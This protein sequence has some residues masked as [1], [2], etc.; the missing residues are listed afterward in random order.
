MH[1][2]WLVLYTRSL[3]WQPQ[4]SKTREEVTEEQGENDRKLKADRIPPFR[5]HNDAAP[6]EPMMNQRNPRGL[7]LPPLS[8]LIGS[9]AWSLTGKGGKGGLQ[10]TLNCKGWNARC[11]VT[12]SRTDDEPIKGEEMGLRIRR[13]QE[14]NAPTI[15]INRKI[16]HRRFR[17]LGRSYAE[18]DQNNTTRLLK[19]AVLQMENHTRRGLF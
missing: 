15:D 17:W 12:L 16:R 3:I 11:L 4:P 13:R 10:A 18:K 1:P 6:P 19:Q 9:S 2:G 8:L 7:W 5:D 14:C